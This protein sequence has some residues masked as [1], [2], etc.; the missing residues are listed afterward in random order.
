MTPTPLRIGILSTA[1]IAKSFVQ[2]IRSSTLVIAAA[3]ASRNG[4]RARDFAAEMGIGQAY[5]CYERLLAD[6][7]IDAIYNPLPNSMHADWSIRALKAGKHVLCE[8]PLAVSAAEARTM[9]AAGKSAGKILVEAYP[10]LSQP[11]TQRMMDMINGGAIG[12]VQIIQ[13]A[14]GFTM[15]DE[16][17]IRL[18][19]SMGGGALF[20][21]GVYPLSLVRRVTGMLPTRVLA[22]AQRHRSGVD[23]SVLASLE[24]ANGTLAQVSCSFS[25]AV[26][27]QATIAGSEGII[28][29]SYPNT[30]PEGQSARFTIRRGTT[31]NSVDEPV[32]APAL[33]G[34]LAEAESFCRM[35]QR[36]PEHWSGATPTESVD[37]LRTVEAIFQS[38]ESGGPVQLI[39]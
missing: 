11:Q 36:G 39:A 2:G 4:V 3:V 25:T 30:P 27:R 37:I 22:V 33:N 24:H 38:A 23:R 1:R 19:P 17:N 13:A 15:S 34:F 14:F 6:P 28:H 20:D 8:K 10:Y 9:F 32:D 31:W 35:I 12:K 21:A 7:S 18:D 29:T 26:H 5:D 16:S